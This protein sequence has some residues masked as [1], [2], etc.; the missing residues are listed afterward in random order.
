MKFD[1]R[2]G[3]RESMATPRRMQDQIETW[4][5]RWREKREAEDS[6]ERKD[7][8]EEGEKE[9]RT[10]TKGMMMMI[11]DLLY[12]YMNFVSLFVLVFVPLQLKLKV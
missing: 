3:K 4:E 7:I 2:Q 11:R 9:R 1:V 8:E 5:R 12:L 6:G 10:I